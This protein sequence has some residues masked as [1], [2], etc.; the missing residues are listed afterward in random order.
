MSSLRSRAVIII[1]ALRV[2]RHML[3]TIK[4]GLRGSAQCRLGLLSQKK[5]PD[6]SDAKRQIVL[7]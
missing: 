2:M 4:L 6:D 3:G 7:F 5:A 1:I